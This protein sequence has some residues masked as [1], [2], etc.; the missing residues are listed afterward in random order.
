MVTVLLTWKS[1]QS[2]TYVFVRVLVY[3]QVETAGN[4]AKFTLSL[5]NCRFKVSFIL[6]K[7]RSIYSMFIMDFQAKSR[8]YF[9]LMAD[10]AEI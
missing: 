6:Q 5:Q 7:I 2:V 8:D 3:K 10:K 1:Q 4:G 9:N